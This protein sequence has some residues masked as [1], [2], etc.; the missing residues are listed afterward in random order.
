MENQE[1]LKEEIKVEKAKAREKLTKRDLLITVSRAFIFF[2]LGLLLGTRKMIFES[3]PLAYALLS[4]SIRQTPF[5]FLGI[6]TSAFD[7]GKLSIVKIVGAC[8]VVSIRI[9]SR[10]YLDKERVAKTNENGPSVPPIAQIFSEHTYL[11]VMSSALG[12][13]LVGIWKIIEGGFRFYDLFGAIFYLLLTP[14]AT[15]LFCHYFNVSEQKI[16]E[17]HA[18]SITPRAEKLY[19]ISYALIVCAF[20]FSLDKITLLGMSAPLFFA[21][22]FTLYATKKGVIYGIVGGLLFGLSISPTYAPTFAFCAIAYASIY[23]LSLFGAGVASCI[24]GLIWC[25]YVGGISSLAAD[26]PALLSSSMLFC[27]AERIN[28]F[29]DIERV[30]APENEI[31]EHYCINSMIAEQKNSLKDEKLRSISDSFSNLSEIF[32]NLSS[33]LKRPTMLDLRSICEGSFEKI[34]ENC[35]NRDLCYGAEY[36]ATLDAMKKITVQLHS[37]GVVEEKKLPESFKKRCPNIKILSGDINK[38]CSIATK[39]AFQNEK[40]EIFA[41]DYDAISKILNDAISEN[42]DDFKI[43]SQMSKKV[44]QVIENEGYGNHNVSVFGK[45]KLRIL[46]RGLDLSDQSADISTLKRRLEDETGVNLTNPTFELSYGSVNMQTEAKRAYFSDAAFANLSS[47][48]ESVCGDTVSIF[49]NKNDYF[50][51]LISDGMGTGKNAALT[52]EICNVFLRNMLTAGNRMETSLRMLNSVLRIKGSKSEAEC[53]A[54]VDLLQFDLYTGDLTLVKS[55]AAP[56]FVV[57]RGNVFKLA[58]PSF[59]I[60]ILRALDAKQ[61]NIQCEDG[62]I[63]VMVSD[64]ATRGGDDCSYLNSLLREQSIADETPSKIADKIIRRAKS[65]IDAQNDDI[66]VVV[67]KVK[68]EICNW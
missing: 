16:R 19:D 22:L 61:L 59:P 52:S 58:S 33:K 1:I 46:A 65:E 66:S 28:I 25:I 56:T 32:Y 13:F 35:E 15:W 37:F 24:A 34:C 9:V 2:M 8:A 11:R 41:L 31:E 50:Y 20:L 53:S 39:K 49:E 26:F 44:A 51:A 64:G 21:V 45:R 40:T 60:G 48:G 47:D 6:L 18:F 36:S 63:I 38:T 55:G 3:V 68:K 7:G 12:V 29:D 14:T 23:K 5:V 57:R 30:F 67:V 43:D 17:G 54:T 42:E 10:L 4:S 27:T 62:D